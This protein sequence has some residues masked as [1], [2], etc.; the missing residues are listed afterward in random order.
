MKQISLSESGFLDEMNLVVVPWSELVSLLAPYATG[1]GAKGGRPPFVVANL[2]RIFFL[3]QWFNLSDPAMEKAL[4]DI[5]KVKYKGL[6]KNTAN[7]VTL[8]A[9]SNLWMARKALM[10][11]ALVQA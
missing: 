1:P 4:H 6:V 3:Q 11:P 10:K 5:T 2:L 7:V 8:F 9:P